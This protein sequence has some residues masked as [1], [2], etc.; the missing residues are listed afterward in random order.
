[1][2]HVV[3]TRKKSTVDK[4][5]DADAERI[6][7]YIH[8]SASCSIY[9]LPQYGRFDLITQSHARSPSHNTHPGIQPPIPKTPSA[10]SPQAIPFTTALSIPFNSSNAQQKQQ[11]RP[12]KTMRT[13]KREADQYETGK[14]KG[15]ERRTW[16][17]RS[18]APAP[19]KCVFFGWSSIRSLESKSINKKD[20]FRS[21]SGVRGYFFL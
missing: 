13:L 12:P 3:H 1:M 16:H 4:R 21:L 2:L 18:I 8:C 11:R 7:S 5:C 15:Q 14:T 10:R 9:A 17:A 19:L 6:L 20:R